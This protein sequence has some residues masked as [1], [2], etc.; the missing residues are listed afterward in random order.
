MAACILAVS[1]PIGCG[2]LGNSEET[3]DIET[4]ERRLERATN[5][6]VGVAPEITTPVGVRDLAST[7]R[8][9]SSTES[10]LVL[11]F[12]T[13]RATRQA[14]RDVTTLGRTRVF[15]DRNVVVLYTRAPGLDKRRAIER[16]LR[17]TPT[18]R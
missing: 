5:I 3:V 8:G 7:R 6:G 18:D 1:L 13:A 17:D 16:A 2:S 15:R 9:Q 14:A 12:Y 11:E 4:L 10:L